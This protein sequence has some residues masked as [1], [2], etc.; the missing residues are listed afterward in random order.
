M[1]TTNTASFIALLKGI[2]NS[3][4]M[5]F[6]CK[7]YGIVVIAA[8]IYGGVRGFGNW[9]NWYMT[10]HSLKIKYKLVEPIVNV[11]RDGGYLGWHVMMSALF[12]MVV[13]STAPISVPL[14]VHYGKE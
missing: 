3:Q 9:F 12:T 11:A 1:S 10:R 7:I 6:P 14:L 8:T 2:S 5:S 4:A 13:A